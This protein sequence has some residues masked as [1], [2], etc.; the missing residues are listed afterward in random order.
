LKKYLIDTDIAIFYMK[1]RF[2]LEAKF[3]KIAAG[4]WQ[5]EVNLITS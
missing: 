3:D 4:N 1:G 2:N 5:K